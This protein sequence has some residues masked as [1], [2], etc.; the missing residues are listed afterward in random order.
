MGLTERLQ[1][2]GFHYS[3]FVQVVTFRRLTYRHA[4]VNE[5]GRSLTSRCLPV[6]FVSFTSD[7][8]VIVI[9]DVVLRA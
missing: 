3:P 5:T 8:G 9:D 7:R 6:L 2:I 4:L 1:K